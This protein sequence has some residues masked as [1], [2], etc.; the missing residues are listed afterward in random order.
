[1]CNT[2]FR[3]AIPVIIQVACCLFKLT[4]G[5]SLFICSEMFAIGKSTVSAILRDVVHAINDTMRQ[6]LTWPTG[7]RLLQT[8]QNFYDLCGLPGVMGAID[9]TH[10]PISKPKHC[11]ADYYY[12]KSG[13]YSLNCQAVVDSDKRFLD[14]Y[15][16]MPGSTNESR[17]LRCS[18]LYDMA[19]HRTLVDNEH[20]FLGFSL[21]LIGDLGYPLLPW[22]M[23]LHCTTGPMSVADRL[24]NKKLRRG[25]CVVEN[26]FGIL[27]LTFR[28][29]LTKSDLNVAFLPDVI[30]VCAILH[31]VLL[32]QLHE[33]VENFLQ[34][35][36][37]EGLHGEVVD[38][39]AGEEDGGDGLVE[40]AE[41]GMPNAVAAVVATD[42]RAE[43]GNF[44]TTQCLRR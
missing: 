7:E 23:V 1:M 39:G 8:E 30:L 24:F 38:E 44:L 34:V 26:A 21:Y 37:N 11:P 29:F 40:I 5:A 3:L 32:G 42:K 43:L 33:E 25:R 28:E 14:L 27:K 31:N 16:G 4:Q 9:G 41:D 36:R 35:L 17:V 22:F 19:M 18:T 15:L 6:E 2:K 10:V 12:F 13:A 20:E